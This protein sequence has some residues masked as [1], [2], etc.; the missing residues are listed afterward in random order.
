MFVHVDKHVCAVHT[1]VHISRQ[2]SK[3]KHNNAVHTCQLHGLAEIHQCCKQV[4]FG[5]RP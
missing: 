2:E 1:C 4:Q 5:Q 3:P